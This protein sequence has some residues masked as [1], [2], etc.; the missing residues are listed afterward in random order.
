MA[1]IYNNQGNKRYIG[2]NTNEGFEYGFV[3]TKNKNI[4]KIIFIVLLVLFIIGSIYLI[5]KNRK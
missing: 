3:I 2:S 1:Y 5:R 4:S